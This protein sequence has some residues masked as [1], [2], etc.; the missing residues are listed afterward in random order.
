MVDGF[1]EI[2]IK[3]DI[4]ICERRD[5][6]GLYRKARAGT[7]PDFTGVS[8][9]YEPPEICELVIDTSYAPI[10]ESVETLDAFVR[11][12]CPLRS[13]SMPSKTTTGSIVASKLER[14]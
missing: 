5:V 2:Y 10:S 6:K 11:T 9:P 4:E 7:V 14:E 13:V 12:Q 8:A 1:H 3:A